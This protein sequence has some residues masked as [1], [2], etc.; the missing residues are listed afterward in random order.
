MYSEGALSDGSGEIECDVLKVQGLCPMKVPNFEVDL[1]WQ[2]FAYV[3]VGTDSAEGVYAF[4]PS[5]GICFQE[6]AQS[7]S[8]PLE[9]G[10]VP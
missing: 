1:I 3:Y 7:I 10:E 9:E 4:L 8:N 6:A 5:R 2:T